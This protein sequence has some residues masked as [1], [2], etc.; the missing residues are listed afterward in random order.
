MKSEGRARSWLTPMFRE[1][2]KPIS[3]LKEL[4]PRNEQR[5]YWAYPAMVVNSDKAEV[6][7]LKNEACKAPQERAISLPKKLGVTL[8]QNVLCADTTLCLCPLILRSLSK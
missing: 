5:C 6:R 1:D 2:G 8:N 3:M 7:K 4:S